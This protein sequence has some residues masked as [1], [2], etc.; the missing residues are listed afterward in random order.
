MEGVS[1][2]NALYHHICLINLSRIFWVNVPIA[3]I[4]L[5]LLFVLLHLKQAK[6][7]FRNQIKSMDWL[8]IFL[9][10]VSLV[11]VLYALLSGG[12]VFPW[13]S[14]R[15]IAPVIIGGLAFIAFIVYESVVAGKRFGPEPLI[16]MRIFS[17]KTASI[18]YSVVLLHAVAWCSL[19]FNFPLYVRERASLLSRKTR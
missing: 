7:S 9:I 18:G 4:A 8:G 6:Q 17:P 10:S 19:A 5:I 1:A 15:I 16:P 2:S 13:R 12:I 14:P 3:T 11:G